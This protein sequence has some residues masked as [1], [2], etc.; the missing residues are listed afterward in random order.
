MN[1]SSKPT[2]KDLEIIGNNTFVS[3]YGRANIPAKIDTGA[4]SSSIWASN[5][6]ITK[7]GILKFRLFGP[8]SP[9]YTGKVIK[10]SD[11]KVAS[12]RSSNGH[13]QIRY[14]TKLKFKIQ[15]RTIIALF[16][17]SDRQINAFPVL[18]GRRTLKNKFLVDVSSQ[19]IKPPKAVKTRV[20]AQEL[21][22]NPRKFYKKY[23]QGVSS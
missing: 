3:L 8:T 5:I 21:A 11:Y 9:F 2:S 20:L 16:N 13:A 19:V 12:V 15:N 14:R 23:H 6:K 17:L 10:R 18:I 7:D 22:K 1:Q 4:D